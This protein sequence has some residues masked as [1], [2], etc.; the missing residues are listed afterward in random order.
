[1]S[2]IELNAKK[3]IKVEAGPVHRT[4][5]YLLDSSGDFAM[6]DPK[7]PIPVP[8]VSYEVEDGKQDEHLLVIKRSDK[9]PHAVVLVGDNFG[10]GGLVHIL[11]AYGSVTLAWKNGKWWKIT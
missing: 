8:V 2:G 7:L 5:V 9:A 6:A 3:L 11:A 4:Q 10:E 1:V